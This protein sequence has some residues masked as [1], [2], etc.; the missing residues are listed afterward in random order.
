[1]LFLNNSDQPGHLSYIHGMLPPLETKTYDVITGDVNGDS[2]P[3]IFFANVGKNSLLFNTTKLPCSFDLD[4]DG[5]V[6]GLD[7]ATAIDQNSFD[8]A[9]DIGMFSKQFGKSDC[10]E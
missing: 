5:D 4:K 10:F 7:L 8:E 9:E 3:D 6:D 1:M 2:I